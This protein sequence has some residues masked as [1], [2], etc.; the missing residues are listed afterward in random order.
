[1]V[2]VVMIVVV[3][4][5]MVGLMRVDDDHLLDNTVATVP[6]LAFAA[7]AMPVARTERQDERDSGEERG[8]TRHA[9]FIPDRRGGHV[10]TSVMAR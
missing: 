9:S 7:V 3:I 8:D 4:V 10:A 5:V 1:M 2:V 6:A